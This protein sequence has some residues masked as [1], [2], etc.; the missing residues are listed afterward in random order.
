MTVAD[1]SALNKIFVFGK[2]KRDETTY[3]NELASPM[4]R[5]R[6]L[7]AANRNGSNNFLFLFE[8]GNH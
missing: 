6:H 4:Q 2:V 1:E 8:T 7:E 5:T 3:A